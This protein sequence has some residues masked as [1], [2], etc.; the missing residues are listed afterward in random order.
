[1]VRCHQGEKSNDLKIFRPSFFFSFE[2]AGIFIFFIYC[3]K[4]TCRAWNHVTEIQSLNLID[5]KIVIANCS[6][7]KKTTLLL[8]IYEVRLFY[9]V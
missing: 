3:V 2:S 7:K 1:M 9:S 5:C 4:Y 6:Q 8:H